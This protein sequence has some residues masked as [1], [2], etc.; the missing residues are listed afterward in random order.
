MLS[1]ERDFC[2][3][4]TCPYVLH[5]AL[6]QFIHAL[7][8]IIERFQLWFAKV[9]FHCEVSPVWMANLHSV[10]SVLCIIGIGYWSDIII[11]RNL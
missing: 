6:C 8:Y 4:Y 3:L 7:F 2:V 10:F 5:L 1:A 9:L 11:C